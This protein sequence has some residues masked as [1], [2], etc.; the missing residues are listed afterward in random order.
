MAII[1]EMNTR[2]SA[3]RETSTGP[4]GQV[5]YSAGAVGKAERTALQFNRSLYENLVS[6]VEVQIESWNR[7]AG[8]ESNPQAAQA[9]RLKAEALGYTLRLLDAFQLEFRELID[10]ANHSGPD[11]RF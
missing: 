10:C 3:Q 1:K 6:N 9:F 5:G 7:Q 2:R 11:G 8:R 4:S